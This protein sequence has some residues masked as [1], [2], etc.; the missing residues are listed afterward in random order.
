MTS[1]PPAKSLA[2][3]PP[4]AVK[5][6]QG[7]GRFGPGPAPPPMGSAAQVPSDAWKARTTINHGGP[8]VARKETAYM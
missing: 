8:S 1:P 2:V 3:G 5:L 6:T 7:R 4:R